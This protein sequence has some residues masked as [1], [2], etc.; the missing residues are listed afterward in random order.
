VDNYLD[1]ALCFNF[2]LNH[3]AARADVSHELR[4]NFMKKLQAEHSQ[5]GIRGQLKD[6]LLFH[7]YNNKTTDY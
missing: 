4:H 6:S 7:Y 2:G 5:N 3:A 1:A